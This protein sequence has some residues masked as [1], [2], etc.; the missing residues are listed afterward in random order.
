MDGLQQLFSS[1]LPIPLWQIVF[2]V[3]LVSYFMVQ[4]WFKLS[5]LTSFVLV[6]YWLHYAFRADLVA[7]TSEDQLARAIYYV[8]GFALL[9]LSIFALT[10]LEVDADSLLEKREKEITALKAQ[11]KNAEKIAA[12][13]QADLEK[14]QSPDSNPKKKRE[15]KLHAKIEKLEHELQE[16]RQLLQTRS[17]E[18]ATLQTQATEEQKNASAFEALLEMYQTQESNSKKKL[19]DDLNETIEA[20]QLQLRENESLLEQRNAEIS[21]LQARASELEATASNLEARSH[22]DS[23]GPSTSSLERV[24]RAQIDQLKD[25]LD[26]K[27]TLLEKRYAEV[28]ALRARASELEAHASTVSSE[29]ENK[30]ANEST[31]ARKREEEL[32]FQIGQL[33]N[34]LK[35]SE[36]LLKLRSAE[37]AE[38]RSKAS[39]AEK[40]T[41]SL[42][43]QLEKD[44]SQ[45][46]ISK[47]KLE[48]KLNARIAKFENQLKQGEALLEKR[49]AEIAE[50]H[51]KASDAEKHVGAVKAQFEKD[52]AQES[53]I[54]KKLQEDL[55]AR[56][57]SL[58][59]QLRQAETLL[60]TREGEIAELQARAS[61]AETDAS[62]LRAQLEKEKSALSIANE[63]LEEEFGAG[64]AKLENQ[65]KQSQALVEERNTEIAQLQVQAADAEK[66]ALALKAR[67]EQAHHSESDANRKVERELNGKIA[68][69]EEKLTQ[70]ETLLENRNSE[71][72]AL[73]A[74]A[75]GAE[76]N[77]GALVAQLEEEKTRVAAAKTK[78]EEE[79]GI[80]ISALENQLQRN[81]QDLKTRE[82]EIAELKAQAAQAEKSAATLKVQLEKDTA[83]VF[84]SKKT[85]DELNG[86]IAKL[87][88]Q[89]KEGETL[90]KARNSE[91]VALRAKAPEAEKSS[92]SLKER[93]KNDTPEV[94]PAHK[95]L[96]AE[97]SA[98]IARLENQLKETEALLEKRNAEVAGTAARA[99]EGLKGGLP[100]KPYAAL[101]RP[102]TPAQGSDD[103][104]TLEEDVRR[105]LHQF[106]YAVK[107][108][109]DEIKEKDRLLGLMAK[110]NA[111]TQGTAKSA[112][113]EDFKKKI[114][115][116]EQAVKYL[117]NQGKE[118]D[119]L[120]GLM[121]KRNQEL[122]D[123]KSKA[124]ER[125]E[126]L[127]ANIDKS[128]TSKG[129]ETTIASER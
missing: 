11:A 44:Q 87:E 75:S 99:G 82:I 111:Q 101:N 34:A 59:G 98:K 102:S 24:L 118:K 68:S 77:T 39:E 42:K 17:A 97:L 8:L 1:D 122:A 91:I 74:R 100:I 26:D 125:L 22:T 55:S 124:E 106:Q 21:T 3:G 47:K 36:G 73:Q 12:A 35:E 16:A 46:S 88:A 61:T 48:E 93:L 107:Y 31:A 57:S 62:S 103:K 76:K 79:Y 15:K 37:A 20:L 14:D 56:L 49:N 90:L 96:E 18:I 109:E 40:K 117:E 83:Q 126:A 51:T 94:S 116:L 112:V 71:I 23:D 66:T 52:Q 19:E 113:D 121:A 63:K 13:L 60:G 58:E 27:E 29:F 41:A 4:R 120:L 10:F 110:K 108:L 70:Y 5:F 86:T 50:L 65:L 123:L 38:F 81:E 9:L 92:L 64:I 54:S 80:K 6:L 72:M 45:G 7:I 114:H 78:L 95:K 67:L 28:A 33:A 25:A 30:L 128:E 53:A 84:V 129:S 127:E 85:S 105:K 115:Q 89:L 119:G 2:Y 43:T 32:T 104:S 69:L